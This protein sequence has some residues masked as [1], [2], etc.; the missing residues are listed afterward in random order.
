MGYK[1]TIFE[2]FHTTGG[3]LTYGIPEFRLPKT[4]VQHEIDKLAQ[5]GVEIKVNS[6]IGKTLT[7]EDLREMGYQAFFVAVGAGLPAFLNI[8]GTQLIGVLSANEYLTR[9][10]L[11]KAYDPAY[12]TMVET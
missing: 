5:S 4:L 9:V 8:P 12:D 3:V 7:L 11:M 6:V 2:A 1:T 10:N